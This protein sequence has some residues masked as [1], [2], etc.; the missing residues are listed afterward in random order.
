M[1]Q[2]RFHLGEG[3]GGWPL[4]RGDSF[5]RMGRGSGL[6]MYCAEMGGFTIELAEGVMKLAEA[7]TSKPGCIEKTKM[8]TRTNIFPEKIY[9]K[10]AKPF[11][12]LATKTV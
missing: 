3:R 7:V 5:F 4:R 2:L 11:L 12:G 1:M 8:N 9:E 10:D 6:Q